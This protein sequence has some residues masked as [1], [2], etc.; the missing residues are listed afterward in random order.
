MSHSKG[1]NWRQV[2]SVTG[3]DGYLIRQALAYAVTAIELLPQK[4]QEWSNAQGMRLILDSV[5]D[6]SDRQFFLDNARAHLT[7][8]RHRPTTVSRSYAEFVAE[9]TGS[10]GIAK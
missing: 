10:P 1:R 7:G 8:I 5:C 3:R 9:V 4:R 6:P 2:Q